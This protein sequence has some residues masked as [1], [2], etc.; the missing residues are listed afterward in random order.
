LVGA[1]DDRVHVRGVLREPL[2]LP[3]ETGRQPG[4]VVLVRGLLVLEFLPLPLEPR[5]LPAG[6]QP[7]AERVRRRTTDR[8]QRDLWPLSIQKDRPI[9]AFL[10]Q[11]VE[12]SHS[13]PDIQRCRK[14][15]PVMSSAS[16]G[17]NRL[18]LQLQEISRKVVHN[19]NVVPWQTFSVPE[20]PPMSA[21]SQRMAFL[22]SWVVTAA[23][24]SGAKAD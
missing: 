4:D 5:D 13:P 24:A 17:D 20:S 15:E 14:T 19:A 1:G 6:P 16:K 18:R 3:L 7:R 9:C 11:V 10:C 22:Q 23:L 12:N 8:G 21:G 2:R